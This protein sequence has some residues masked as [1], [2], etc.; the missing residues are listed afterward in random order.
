MR[1][2][3]FWLICDDG[4]VR[5]VLDGTVDDANGTPV[6]V[7]FL[8]DSGADRTVFSAEVHGKL[9]LATMAPEC[10]IGGVGGIVDS[11]L[12][13]ASLR[14]VDRDGNAV[15]FEG[16]VPVLLDPEALDM[17]ILGRDILNLFAVILDRPGD[18]VCLH[19]QPHGYAT[20]GS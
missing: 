10:Q 18:C 17:S 5:P 6:P 2:E 20:T 7:R 15:R 13:E 19:S 1:I 4:V 8:I 14:L 16:R 12:V 9:G 3:G 11:V